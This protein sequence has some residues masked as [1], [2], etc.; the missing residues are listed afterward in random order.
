ML[1]NNGTTRERRLL[2]R[3]PPTAEYSIGNRSQ[4]KGVC[5]VF[6][7]QAW[8]SA[9]THAA[10]TLVVWPEQLECRRSAFPERTK[11]SLGPCGLATPRPED[12]PPTRPLPTQPGR[13]PSPPA[14]LSPPPGGGGWSRA[15]MPFPPPPITS[16]LQALWDW[17]RQRASSVNLFDWLP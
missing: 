6:S 13:A 8:P 10:T 1:A 3:S 16:G 5:P 2:L 7:R 11:F 17:L 12:A 4:T 15:S 14:L 9:D